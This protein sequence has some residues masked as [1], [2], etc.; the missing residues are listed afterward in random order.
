[1]KCKLLQT[2][3]IFLIAALTLLSLVSPTGTGASGPQTVPATTS[4]AQAVD[5]VP[6]YSITWTA[7][8]TGGS[9]TTDSDGSRN[10]Y[11]RKITTS[12]FAIYREVP[13]PGG[14]WDNF[15]LD[16]TITDEYDSYST[17][18]CTP[19]PGYSW[20][21]GTGFVSDPNR[22]SGGPG[23]YVLV[24]DPLQRPDGSWYMLDPL[25]YFWLNE[26]VTYQDDSEGVDCSGNPFVNHY[27]WVTEDYM[28]VKSPG[29]LEGDA[30]GKVF[31]KTTQ[32]QN[33]NTD[34]PL[35]VQW[36]VTV[37]LLEGRDLTV[38]RLEITQ[39][40]QDGGNTLPLVQGRRT[41]VRAYL[42]IG[43]DQIPVPFVTGKLSGYVGS[44][45]L[46]SVPAFNPGG[47][48]TAPVDPNWKQIDHTLNFELPYDWTLQ[49]TLRLEVEVNPD[50]SVAELNY[51]NNKLSTLMTFLPCGVVNV[52]YL[53]IHYTPPGGYSPA[54]PSANINVGAEFMRKIYPIP[55]KG[56]IYYPRNE[57]IE[58]FNIN[59]PGI[60]ISLV[61]GLQN[62]LLSSSAP[63]AEF[64]Y[65]WLPSLA[66]DGNGAGILN[67]TAAFGNDTESPDRWRRTFAHELGHN[68]GFRHPET[69]TAGAHWFDVYDR[70]IKPVPASVGGEYLLDFMVP[71]RLESEA[72]IS[73][74][75]YEYLVDKI[76]SGAAAAVAETTVQSA[77]TED[78]LLVSGII[79]NA[80]PASSSLDPLYHFTTVTTDTLPDGSQYCI[81]LKNAA[82]TL[83][84]QYCFNQDFSGD[85]GTPMDA[86]PFG[87]VVPY[88]TGLNRVELVK[89]G[90][91]LATQIASI[92][93]P[94]ISVTFPN[95]AGLTLSEPQDITW[96]GTDADGG[97]L[98]Y[99]ILYSRDN[100]ATWVGIGSGITGSSYNLDFSGLPGT[101]GA[102]GK[103]KVMVSDGFNSAEDI[104]DNPF[105]I[106]NKAPEAAIISPP[107]GAE[108]TTGPQVVL[109]G[110]GMDLED[111]S[112]GDSALSWVSSLDGALGASQLLEV[113]LSPGVHTITLTATDSGGLSGVASIQ[114]TVVQPAPLNYLFLPIIMR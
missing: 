42:G 75:N 24:I 65:G 52:T 88:P 12:G 99:N 11:N 100:G 8:A 79:N 17:T 6:K 35:T 48:I 73:P 29:E 59:D 60:A 69:T 50:H 34:P 40:L 89:T 91:I 5:L 94:S 33:T 14:D 45:L 55:D 85:S 78:T 61:Y 16:V 31:T 101:T 58:I 19:S 41:V 66:F 20:S 62:M 32:F 81:N 38:K 10:V 57:L 68:Y 107:S 1:M 47:R 96:T 9:D 71:E 108:F 56:L 54:D 49:P 43:K 37:R 109:E 39:G 74:I 113:T 95:A 30:D 46:G 82:N 53:P 103:I 86:V 28:D 106:G 4:P 98:T 18:P 93:P 80:I 44:T 105:S 63:H 114:I 27:K 36:D 104:S 110:A 70:V 7:T 111:G 87:M 67:G 22:Y 77:V 25:S 76:C 21:R 102:S 83:L 72:W 15:P 13:G 2:S 112:L 51:N 23:H 90:Y 26:P 64:I 84:S 97:T 3:N 92:N